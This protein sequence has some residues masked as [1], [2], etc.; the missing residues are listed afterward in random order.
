MVCSKRALTAFMIIFLIAAPSTFLNER[1]KG[2]ATAAEMWSYH[3]SD[4]IAVLLED[5]SMDDPE[6]TDYTTARSLLGTREIEGDRSIP[7]LFLGDPEDDDRPWVMLIG[8][9]HGDEPDSAESV[10]GFARYMLDGWESGDPDIIRILE[11]LNIA[12]LPVVNPWGLDQ[13]SRYDENGEDPNRDYPF[14]PM[15]NTYHS[16]GVPLTTAGAHAVHSLA[17]LYPFSI[18]LSFHTGSEGIF[19]PWGADEV[20]NI[21]PDGNM[22]DDLG[23]VLSRASGRGLVH[24][25]ANDHP[26]LGYLRGAFDD[27]LYGSSFYSQ[28]LDDQ[29]M[30]LP[31]STA[32]ATVE[33]VDT[34]GYTP[35]NLGSLEGVENIGGPDDG[36][37]AAGVRICLAACEMAAPSMEVRRVAEG[38]LNVTINGPASHPELSAWMEVNGSA[39]P[40]DISMVERDGALPGWTFDVHWEDP[41]ANLSGNQGIRCGFDDEWVR[42]VDGSDPDI[43]PVSLLSISRAARN[44]EIS[45]S[46]F[47]EGSEDVD[48][49]EPVM[50]PAEVRITYIEPRRQEIGSAAVMGLI[51]PTSAGRPENI[52]VTVEVGGVKE[53]TD[54]P[55]GTPVNDLLSIEFHTPLVEGTADVEV[56]V[57]TD[58]GSFEARDT[59]ELYPDVYISNLIREPNHQAPDNDIFR[60]IIGVDGGVSDNTIFYGLSRDANEPWTG[61]GWCLGPIGVISNE[62]GPHTLKLDLN[63]L[64]GQA[65]LRVCHHPG[66]D[67][68][69]YMLKLSS[70]PKVSDMPVRVEGE[71]LI[72]GPGIMVLDRDG[73]E[74]ID[75][76]APD[77]TVGYDLLDKSGSVIGT[78]ELLWM[79]S[80]SLNSSDREMVRRQAA[81]L[82]L[83]P[84]QVTGAWYGT[85]VMPMEQAPVRVRL[86][87]T[88]TISFENEDQPLEIDIR[89]DLQGNFPIVEEEKEDAQG[90]FPYELFFFFFL[91]A[92]LVLL[93]SYLRRD[94]HMVRHKDDIR[95]DAGGAGQGEKMESGPRVRRAPPPPWGSLK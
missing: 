66:G 80:G 6:I 49:Q 67:E 26:Y 22:F 69:S 40:A 34:K 58:K 5:W 7:I 30:I 4:E 61:T 37:V 16:D 74:E 63:D 50:V 52:T 73:L 13:G 90:G 27:H 23:N 91:M 54:I 89:R 19:T 68:D 59:M 70:S 92:L 42:R 82:S 33:L 41:V 1:E 51:V 85:K 57:T 47:V 39:Y 45:W 88:G 31:W 84:G 62:Y 55:P 14:V 9:H 93:L 38:Q 2:A 78:Y 53:V 72:I 86:N 94:A 12:V 43:G 24:G 83:S 3:T 60:L 18:A 21:T 25:P 17:E 15:G 87:V 29:G 71:E 44:G 79:R 75:Q 76:R 11:S 28:K 48:E 56:N 32:T 20:G 8:A 10:L 35:Y 36:V 77:L 81:L 46:E 65:F 95:E 64:G